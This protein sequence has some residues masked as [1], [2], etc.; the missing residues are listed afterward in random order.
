M[1]IIM[2]EG[3]ILKNTE[4]SPHNYLFM[5]G[6]ESKKT[7][8]RMTISSK[9][10]NGQKDENGYPK[11]N[12]HTVK[13]FGMTAEMINQ[14]FGEG[15][16]VIISGYLDKS[17][18]WTNP[19]DGKTYPPREEIIANSVWMADAPKSDTNGAAS[20]TT[21]AATTKSTNARPTVVASTQRREVP[22]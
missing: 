17:D 10:M 8:L 5:P 15:A 20:R 4:N 21:V 2:I 22:F 9:K 14:Y 6:N 7:F 19:A 11:T 16:R 1:N 12:L 18:E 13:A 3:R